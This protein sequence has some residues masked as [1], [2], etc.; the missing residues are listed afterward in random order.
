[1]QKAA[2]SDLPDDEETWHQLM[3]NLT[4]EWPNGEPWSLI[5]EDAAKPALLQPPV[6]GAD[7]TAFKRI[8]TPDA[9]DMLITAKNH[10]LKAERMR[11]AAPE[12]WLFS[13]LSLTNPRR[14]HGRRQLW[15]QPDEWGL[16]LARRLRIRIE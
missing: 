3:A 6:P 12:D 8:E 15:H 7:L 2:T 1:M 9:L 13:L 14:G 16:W 10:D 4:P 5:V 11:A